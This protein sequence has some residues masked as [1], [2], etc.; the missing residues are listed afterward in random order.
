LE[1]ARFNGDGDT[2][3]DNLIQSSLQQL[4][5]DADDRAVYESML[6]DAATVLY[7]CNADA[8]V[9]AWR[10]SDEFAEVKLHDLIDCSLIKIVAEESDENYCVVFKDLWV[11]DV[12]KSIATREAHSENKQ[13][14]K[15]VWLPDQVKPCDI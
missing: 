8:A 6:L 14:M 11:H 5:Y 13:C 9:C 3:V 1:A 15:R 10:V 2:R 7:G 12:I 4:G